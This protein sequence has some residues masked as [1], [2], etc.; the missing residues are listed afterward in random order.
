MADALSKKVV[1]EFAATLTVVEVDFLNKI[2][3]QSQSDVVH[4]KLRI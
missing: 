1:Q 2:K 4:Q 3:E